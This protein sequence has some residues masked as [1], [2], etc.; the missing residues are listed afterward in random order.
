MLL[1]DS[2]RAVTL[3]LLPTTLTV[4]LVPMF[5]LSELP[6]RLI[7]LP[8]AN[9]IEPLFKPTVLAVPL[10]LRMSPVPPALIVAPPPLT[11]NVS[12]LP[13]ALMMA[14]APKTVIA[15]P[16][17]AALIV[18][19]LPVMRTV[20]LAP[21]AVTFRLL[22]VAVSELFAPKL[23]VSLEPVRFAE[24][25]LTMLKLPELIPTVSPVPLI[26]RLSPVPLKL[27]LLL[28]PVTDRVSLLPP[29]MLLDAP[30]SANPALLASVTRP[31][32]NV[33]VSPVPLTVRASPV[34]LVVSTSFDPIVIA[35][36]LPTADSVALLPTLTV[37]LLPVSATWLLA[38]ML[39]V[40]RCRF[41][42]SPVPLMLTMSPCPVVSVV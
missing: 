25:P 36:L 9:V 23:T 28:L 7:L 6:V 21:L 5:R 13:A 29:V 32:L 40:P 31:E 33:A 16:A 12:L 11:L 19:L 30:V 10:R 15:S 41:A 22:P 3:S 8:S 42:V 39:S 34:P 4:S 17:P 1:T 20:S 35:L 27:T 18:A 38:A 24:L 2:A 14:P 26:A 37:S